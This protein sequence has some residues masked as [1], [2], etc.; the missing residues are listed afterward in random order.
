MVAIIIVSTFQSVP[1]DTLKGVVRPTGMGATGTANITTVTVNPNQ[2]SGAVGGAQDG[3][4]GQATTTKYVVVTNQGAVV[5]SPGAI[6][7]DQGRTR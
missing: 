6:K 1:T 2:I 4:T 3:T 7:T 5:T